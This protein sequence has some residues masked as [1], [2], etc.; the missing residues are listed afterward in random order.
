MTIQELQF[1]RRQRVQRDR[2]AMARRALVKGGYLDSGTE[3]R[4][5]S[6][7]MFRELAA[8][9][10]TDIIALAATSG[11][12]TSAQTV[13]LAAKDAVDFVDQEFGQW[14]DSP[15]AKDG[16]NRS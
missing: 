6:K 4:E 12:G 10:L 14:P 5:L 11:V 7:E 8:D 9:I 2:G 15:V 13:L 1:A 16:D 3:P